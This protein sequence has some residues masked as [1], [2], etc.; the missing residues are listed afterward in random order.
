MSTRFARKY[1]L[2][3]RCLRDLLASIDSHT[4]VYPAPSRPVTWTLV[5]GVFLTIC[6]LGA[7]APL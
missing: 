3:S 1:S 7:L 4:F 2:D 5:D 6:V